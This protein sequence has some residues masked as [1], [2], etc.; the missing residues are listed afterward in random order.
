MKTVGYV[1]RHAIRKPL[2]SILTI[3]SIAICMVPVMFLV[4]YF[5]V[6]EELAAST[7]GAYRL[8]TMNRQ[9]LGGGSVPISLVAQVDSWKEDG[10]VAATP[11]SW[12]GGKLGEER[13]DFAQFGVYADRIFQ[14]WDELILPDDQKQAFAAQRSSCLI[15]NKLAAERSLKVGDKVLLKGDIYP[16]DLDM[17]VVGI[18][19]GPEEFDRR[20]VLFHWEYMEEAL[21]AS[22]DVGDGMTGNAGT[23]FLKCDS[24]AAM[25]RLVD[26]IDGS[27]ANSDTP[28]RTQDEEAF[29]NMFMEMIGDLRY[30]LLIVGL[31]VVFVLLVVAGVSM[32]M[33]I[34][35]RTTEI[36]VLKAIGFPRG[37]ILGMVLLESILVA[38]VG[39]AL[40]CFGMRA[41]FEVVDGAKLLGGFLPTFYIP[42]PVALSGFALS[43]AI[44]LFS[45]LIP[46]IQASRLSVI[47]G[48]RK[49]V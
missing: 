13:A 7:K 34:R 31:A 10:V 15:G 46:A 24:A 23:I 44:G 48:L 35:E 27:T 49:V 47:N 21:K 12:F 22:P 25:P 17:E 5:R 45:G 36:A 42:W 11:F 38:G 39:G 32:G 1:L 6:N 16:I 41:L 18:Y 33:A 3:L 30:Y 8:I 2:G 9:G 19:D 29:S 37:R 26:K 20:M 4:S 14:V 43:L 28:T 40:G